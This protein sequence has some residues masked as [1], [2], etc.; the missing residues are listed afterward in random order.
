M[1][2]Y[3]YLKQNGYMININEYD[4]TEIAKF[5]RQ[6]DKS[7]LYLFSNVLSIFF[8]CFITSWEISCIIEFEEYTIPAICIVGLICALYF[9]NHALSYRSVK[10]IE[11]FSDI[12]FFLGAL[13]MAY[14]IKDDSN[15]QDSPAAIGALISILPASFAGTGRFKCKCSMSESL[16]KRNEI[17]NKQLKTNISNLQDE[18]NSKL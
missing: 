15:L 17:F 4:A 3:D 7:I 13:G 8:I 9:L 6:L 1:A 14:Y 16:M 5:D 18:E 12:L 10:H 11:R 2:T